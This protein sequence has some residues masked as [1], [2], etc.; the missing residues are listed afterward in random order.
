MDLM[1]FGRL[2]SPP[3]W[4][5][6]STTNHVIFHKVN[7]N[8]APLL[9]GRYFHHYVLRRLPLHFK[10]NVMCGSQA[11]DVHGMDQYCPLLQEQLRS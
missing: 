10:H 7:L 6:W 5:R 11:S 3:D 2:V 9:A 1:M 8:T 4:C